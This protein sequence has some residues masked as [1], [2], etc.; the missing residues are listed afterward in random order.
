MRSTTAN[1]KKNGSF[2]TIVMNS[3]EFDDD[4]DQMDQAIM[5]IDEST[6]MPQPATENQ[7]TEFPCSKCI[8][9]FQS[10]SKLKEHIRL[11]HQKKVLITFSNGG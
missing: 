10:P 3:F 6:I 5:A 9:I 7:P 11:R 8:E 4:D 1:R 2:L